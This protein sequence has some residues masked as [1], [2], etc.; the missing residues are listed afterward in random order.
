[1]TRCPS[2]FSSHAAFP[3]T[4][5]GGTASPNPNPIPPALPHAQSPPAPSIFPFLPLVNTGYISCP[6]KMFPVLCLSLSPYSSET[7]FSKISH[8][9]TPSCLWGNFNVLYLADITCKVFVLFRRKVLYLRKLF[10]ILI[11]KLQLT[12][13]PSTSRPGTR[14]RSSLLSAQP[15]N[16]NV[17]QLPSPQGQDLDPDFAPFGNSPHLA[18]P[19]TSHLY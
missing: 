3:S 5:R 1:M 2:A 10:L 15:N 6:Q 13:H 4:P 9:L 11:S 16:R 14:V 7:N 17:G 18:R 19:S 12:Y 8:N